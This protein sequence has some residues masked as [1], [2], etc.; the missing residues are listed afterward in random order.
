MIFA[1]RGD[2]LG[3]LRLHLARLAIL[4]LVLAL[5]LSQ[6]YFAGLSWWSFAPDAAILPDLH[7][8]HLRGHIRVPIGEAG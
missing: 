2:L 7:P 1:S 5:A 4:G 3:C 6:I 8:A